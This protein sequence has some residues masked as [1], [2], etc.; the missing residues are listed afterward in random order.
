MFLNYEIVGMRSAMVFIM[1]DP[2]TSVPMQTLMPNYLPEALC[3]L[4]IFLV[5]HWM[6]NTSE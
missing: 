6:R 5:E 2:E 3:P 1:S 4:I